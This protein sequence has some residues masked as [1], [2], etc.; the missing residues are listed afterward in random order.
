MKKKITE[1]KL[2]KRSV[3]FVEEAFEE[4]DWSKGRLWDEAIHGL[5]QEQIL[6]ENRIEYNRYE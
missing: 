6:Q 3:K 2:D 4:R 1:E 5:I